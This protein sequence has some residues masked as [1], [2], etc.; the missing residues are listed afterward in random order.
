MDFAYHGYEGQKSTIFDFFRG[1]KIPALANWVGLSRN[2]ARN[3]PR[4][5]STQKKIRLVYP[6]YLLGFSGGGKIFFPFFRNFDGSYLENQASQLK[7]NFKVHL[8]LVEIY[9]NASH[10][11][12]EIRTRNRSKVQKTCSKWVFLGDFWA[13]FSSLFWLHF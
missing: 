12:V 8:C 11:K 6:S 4:G 1:R 7:T 5:W 10:D 9:R 2:L 13:I 3:C